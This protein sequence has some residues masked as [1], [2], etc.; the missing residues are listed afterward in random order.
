MFDTLVKRNVKEPEDIHWEVQKRF[1]RKTGVRLEDYTK[2]RIEA[3]RE[4]RKEGRKEETSLEE[5]F[6]HMKGVPEVYKEELLRLEEETEVELCCPCRRIQ[7]FYRRARKTGKPVIITSDMYLN[8]AVVRKILKKCG[9][10]GYE[11]LYLSSS[12]GLCKSTGNLYEEIKKDDPLTKGALLHI[13]DHVKSDFWMAEKSGIKACLVDGRQIHLKYWKQKK[14]KDFRYEKVFSFLNNHTDK[15]RSEAAAIGYEILGPMLLGYCMWMKERMDKDG[16]DKIFFLSREGKLLQEAFAVLYPK[17]RVPQRYLSVSRQSLLVPLLADAADFNGMVETIKCYFHVPVLR[18]VR[19]VCLLEERDFREG[20]AEIGLGED[21]D[22]GGIPDSKKEA[23]YALIAKLGGERFRRQKR[24]VEQ[25]LEENDFTGNVAVADIGWAGTMQNALQKYTEGTDTAVHGYYFGVRNLESDRYYKHMRRNGY[26]FE[27]G[28]NGDYDL[29][30]RFTQGILE[31]LFLNKTGSVQ[32]YGIR[33]EADGETVVPLL[34]E[35]EYGGKEGE[36]IDEAQRSALE[37]LR[38]AREDF[39]QKRNMEIREDDVMHAYANFAVYPN[40]A[41][42]R[43][44]EDFRFA[45]GNVR[46]VL[47]EHNIFY[48]LL[49]AGELKQEINQSICK[50]FLLKKF[51]KIKFPYFRLLRWMAVKLDVQSEYRKKYFGQG[52]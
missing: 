38:S 5:I 46:K 26:L 34:A 19:D 11:K 41:S 35:A 32:A 22:I 52:G 15:T 29:M 30:T 45:D 9:Y 4:A 28:K 2:H 43:V 49:H 14:K 12:Y 50:I 33:K 27:P 25:Y 42:L 40:L 44:F 37:F 7:R 39:V 17:C 8:E 3:E 20:L 36:L 47:P 10:G 23:V 18:T 48:Y 13:G 31:L 21:T 6:R 16:I 1:Y 51:F 24:Y